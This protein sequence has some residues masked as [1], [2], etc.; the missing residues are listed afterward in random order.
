MR[1]QNSIDKKNKALVAQQRTHPAD[2]N[3]LGLNYYDSVS[4]LSILS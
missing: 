3:H 4:W 2:V 1:I